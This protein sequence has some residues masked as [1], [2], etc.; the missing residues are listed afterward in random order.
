MLPDSMRWALA[1]Y[2]VPAIL[3]YAA[4]LLIRGGPVTA[5]SFNYSLTLL[6]VLL[7][8]A[9]I[10]V[11]CLVVA[12]VLAVQSLRFDS[13]SVRWPQYAVLLAAAVPTVVA[14]FWLTQ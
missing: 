13:I 8:S 6:V 3:I 11:V 10:A 1:A 2:V 5:Q 4:V 7:V 12:S 14:A 9:A